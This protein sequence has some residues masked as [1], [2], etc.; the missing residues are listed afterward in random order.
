MC[1]SLCRSTLKNRNFYLLMVIKFSSIMIGYTDFQKCPTYENTQDDEYL[2]LDFLISQTIRM[3]TT[4][5]E[6]IPPTD[7]PTMTP[8]LEPESEKEN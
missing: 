8:V 4:I 7:A 5:R 2:R 6:M 3:M 1:S